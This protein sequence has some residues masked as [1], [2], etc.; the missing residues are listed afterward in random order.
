MTTTKTSTDLKAISVVR[1]LPFAV[2]FVLLLGGFN[3]SVRAED[4]APIV[5]PSVQSRKYSGRLK[6]AALPYFDYRI[7]NNGRFWNTVNNTGMFGNIYGFGDNK[8]RRQAPSF[9]F[10][11]YSRVVHGWYTALWVGGVVGRDTLVTTAIGDAPTYGISSEREFYPEPYPQGGMTEASNR[12]GSPFYTPRADAEQQ[13]TAVYSDTFHNESWVPFNE[14][15]GRRHQPLNIQVTQT[16]YSWSYG[17]AEDFII[18]DYE[19]RNIGDDPIRDAW[20]GLYYQ[21]G[22]YHVSEQPYP[23]LDDYVGLTPYLPTDVIG[24]C[25][26]TAWIA[27]LADN[28]GQPFG[29]NWDYMSTTNVFALAPLRIPEDALQVNFNW[30]VLSYTQPYDW[31]P[32]YKGQ[33]KS[34]RVFPSGNLGAPR[35]DRAKYYLMSYPEIDY[36]SWETAL[37]HTSEG[38]LPPPDF[39]TNIADGHS[40]QYVLSFGDFDLAPGQARHFTLAMIVGEDFHIDPS[41]HAERFDPYAPQ[42][43]V[44]NTS[45]D[46]LHFN[47]RWARSIFDNPGIDT[48]FDGDSGSFY[49]EIDPVSGDSTQVFCSGDG[50]PDFRGATPPPPPEV[51]VIA[52]QGK[53]TV[54]WN[55]RDAENFFDTFSRLRDF[56]GYRVYIARSPTEG[57]ISVLA[58]YDRRNYN[59]F[60][61]NHA[62]RR[63][64]NVELPFTLDSLR[65]LYGPTFDPHGYPPHAPL[66][67][68]NDAYYFTPVDFNYYDLSDPTQI[69]RVYP[70]AENDTSDVDDEGRMRFYEYQYIIENLQ[71]TIPYWVSVTAFDYGYPA[72]RLEPLESSPYVNQVKVYAQNQGDA[73]LDE[74]GKLNVY[75]YPNPYRLDGDYAGRGLE[76][77]FDDLSTDRSRTINFANLPHRCTISIY[78]LDGDLIKRFEHDEPEGSGTA[79]VARFDLITRNTQAL[80]SGLYY[81]VVESSAGTQVGK[82]MVI[83]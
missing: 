37:D 21:G 81:W 19:I 75:V 32:R 57:D 76:N 59:R 67:V 52:E 28:D 4:P 41:N 68:G 60:T 74:S 69:H 39:A 58:S 38:W 55:G 64:E 1:G 12:S 53:L 29:N 15:D 20:V 36:P 83:L 6:A 31:G 77:R 48:N 34:V 7:H 11:K 79:S 47:L 45:F 22:M 56:E 73:V 54:R 16:S 62:K 65:S 3:Q 8:G 49:F 71:P 2:L 14:Y 70:E 9:F 35:G 82:L 80:V 10:P 33:T 66:H 18:V 13:Y 27:W 51:R 50:I 26:S 30:W 43:F 72:K 46:D 44:A 42:S 25:D 63:F 24:E 40:V 23:K 17:Y 61:Y 78:S 5:D